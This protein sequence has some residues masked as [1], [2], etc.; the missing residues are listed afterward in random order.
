[1]SASNW[2][3]CPK[4]HDKWLEDCRAATEKAKNDYGKVAPQDYVA[5]LQAIEELVKSDPS[6]ER[7]REDYE[8]G[9]DKG[10]YSVSY[11]GACSVCDFSFS[12]THDQIVF[13]A[14]NQEGT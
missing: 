8:Q 9:I 3:Q 12:Y 6:E 4:C 7:L 11:R 14:H 13:P 10:E 2:G 1:M 5:A